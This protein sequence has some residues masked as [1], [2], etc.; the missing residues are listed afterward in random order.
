MMYNLGNRSTAP[1]GY[2]ILG[3]LWGKAPQDQNHSRFRN[4]DYDA[5][6]EKFLRTPDGPER[7]ALARRMSDIANNYVPIMTQVY[8]VAHAFTQPWLLGYYPSRTLDGKYRRISVQVNRPGVTVLYRHGYFAT[9]DIAPFN[10]QRIVTYGRVASAAGFPEPVHDIKV[11][12]RVTVSPPTGTAQSVAVAMTIDISRVRFA[13]TGRLRTASI[14][15]AAFVLDGKDKDAGHE[16]K[17]VELAFS[18]DRF[19]D[20]LRDGVPVTLTI[21]V[22]AKPK[23]VK[24][25]VYDYGADLVGS[26]IVKIQ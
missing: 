24:V 20:Y 22:T 16:W 11:E 15:V 3:Q 6:F 9:A 26:D 18:D 7:V 10:K 21:P 23:H 17:T 14:E 4:A 12:T 25:V 13:R 8:P 19:P 2:N 1:S 5:A